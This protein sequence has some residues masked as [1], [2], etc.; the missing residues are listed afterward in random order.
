M[1]PDQTIPPKLPQRFLLW[2][3][4]DDLAEEVLGD[5][6]EKFYIMLE[7]SSLLRARFNYWYQVFHYLR[8]F[9]IR[10]LKSTTY[11][12]N[13]YAMYQSYFKISWRNL[14]KN[15]GYSLI[16]ISGLTVGMTIAMLIGLW[17][18]YEISF[19]TFHKNID[20]IGIIRKHSLF[21]NTK[22]TQL[23]VPLP[24]YEELKNN[25]PEIKRISRFKG[26]PMGLKTDDQIIRK[27]GQYVDPDFLEM[28]SFSLI[29]GNIKTALNDPKSIVL[30]ESLAEILFGDEDPMGKV[31]RID[32]QYDAQVTGIMKDIPNNS[33]F[34]DIEFLAP[35]EY[36]LANSY[37]QR[38]KDDW[39]SNVIWTFLELNEHVSIDKFSDKIG[40]INLEKDPKSRE[41]KLSIQPFAKFHLYDE[42]E[43]WENIGGKIAYVRMFGIIG[44]LVLFIACINF[45]NLSTARSEKRAKEV[46]IRKS[47]GSQRMHLIIQFFSESIMIAFFAYL[48]SVGLIVLCLPYLNDLG[49]ENIAFNVSNVFLWVVGLGVCIITGIVAGSY[50]ALYLSSFQP[51][52]ILKGTFR[53]GKGPVV[54]RK[55]LV[56]SQF[57]ISVG[58]IIG[59]LVVFHQ[60]NYVKNRSIGYNPNHLISILGSNDIAQNFAVL[61]QELLNTGYVEA[62]AKT[63]GPM[64][65]VY[66]KWSDF[67]WDGKDPDAQIALEALM[68]EWDYEKAAGLKFIQGRPFSPEFST[69]SNAVILNETA[70]KVIGYEDPI[71][72]TMTSGGREITI[73]GVVEDVLMLNPF[74]P[75]SPG[76]ILFNADIANTVLVRV[77]P[78]VDLKEALTFIES[79]FEK[80]NSSF[81]FEYSFVDE[82]FNKK[83]AME[84]QVGKLAGLFAV[85]AI[86]I[87]CL[88]LFGLA[89][90]VAEQRTKEIGIRKVLGASVLMLWRM[91]SK[92]FVILV[93]IS[94]FIAIPMAF[95]FMQNWLQQ[96]EYRTEISWW[97]FAAAGIGALVITL[98]TV[99]Y[100]TVKA[101]L[102]N[103][104]K[105]LRSE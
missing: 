19:D 22:G 49:F 67:S 104:V 85:L 40:A 62:V 48:L 21:N 79:I 94:C 63:S 46:G 100:Q 93:I 42:Y 52:K 15:K 45:M 82:E 28:F 76:V 53:Q 75:V 80:H 81:P 89:S 102:M 71:G 30:T 57:V 69:D 13:H 50:P 77:N 64:T 37:L 34:N 88:G 86:F 103:P 5:L 35:F 78:A 51:V 60:I 65:E 55:L 18:H 43:N 95:Y 26:H 10:N 1:K 11:Y 7:E 92:D 90:Y 20:R 72:R 38:F 59:T 39:G 84:N 96:Y 74:K 98:L 33:T 44:I 54:F 3:L 36:T 101:A 12:P 97:I 4:R 47:V 17:V 56:V 9:A 83:F 70:L 66:N 32:N 41:Q 31:V 58:L 8:P 2:F 87:S 23:A 25:Y 24:L 27:I 73:V 16:N 105:S 68:T 29:K 99:S 6:D 14:L 91:L 61:K